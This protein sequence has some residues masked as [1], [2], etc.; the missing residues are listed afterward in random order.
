MQSFIGLDYLFWEPGKMEV[1]VYGDAAV[2]RYQAEIKIKVKWTPDAPEGKFWHNDLYEKRD[3]QWK[4]VWSQ[5][6]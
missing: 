3:G 4:V 5:A 2:I 1:G 6:T